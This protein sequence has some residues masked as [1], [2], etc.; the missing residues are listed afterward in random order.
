MR[1]RAFLPAVPWVLV[2]IAAPEFLGNV[3]SLRLPDPFGLPIFA[4]SLATFYLAPWVGAILVVIGIVKR[5][6]R[7][8]IH[9][10]VTC[11]LSLAI[12][13]YADTIAPKRFYAAGLVPVDGELANELVPSA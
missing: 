7:M 13:V 4:V 11:L 2:L 3:Y 8:A 9:G 6:S 12:L 5:I 1:Y 10:G